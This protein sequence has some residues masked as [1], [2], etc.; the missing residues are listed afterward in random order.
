MDLGAL[1]CTPRNPKCLNC[2]LN[3][4]CEAYALGNQSERPVRVAR[5]ETPHYRV[6]AAVIERDGT[7]LLAQRPL[8]GLLGGLWEFPGGKTLPGEDLETCLRREI[9]EELGVA[10][11]VREPLGKYR[12]AYTHFKVTLFAF[13]CSLAAEAHPQ[14]IVASSLGWVPLDELQAYPMGKLDRLI[15]SQLVQESQPIGSG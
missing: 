8:D 5:P 1:I 9:F 14:P 6:T 15:A 10:I 4:L 11:Q 2:P 12:H 3:S 13:Q 7:Y